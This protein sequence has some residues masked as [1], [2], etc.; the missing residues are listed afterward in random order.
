MSLPQ[1]GQ[2]AAERKRQQRLQAEVEATQAEP[3]AESG[4]YHGGF[5]PE[6]PQG[7][8]YR[9]KLADGSNVYGEFISGKAVPPGT[10]VAAYHSGSEKWLF[11]F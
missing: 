2:E 5:D 3:P 7:E 9:V 10:K 4:F 8:R 1:R 6:A 11:D